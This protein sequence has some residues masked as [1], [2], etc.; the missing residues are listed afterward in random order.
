[1]A[2]SF[3]GKLMAFTVMLFLL[4]SSCSSNDQEYPVAYPDKVIHLN[5]TVGQIK[6]TLS[7]KLEYFDNPIGTSEEYYMT[8]DTLKKY[9]V[10]SKISM[11]FLDDKLVEF[12]CQFYGR[13]ASD[14]YKYYNKANR[15]WESNANF[16]IFKDSTQSTI[17]SIAIRKENDSL[18][19]DDLIGTYYMKFN[20][21][22][23]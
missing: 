9:S 7:R 5:E 4:H 12:N 19:N 14:L 21:H 16:E 8:F 22:N 1:M 11:V 17:E 18:D 3:V 6:K 23:N 20:K 2:N 13:T 10:R 15:K